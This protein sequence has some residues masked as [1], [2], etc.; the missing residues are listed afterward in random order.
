[1][2]QPVDRKLGLEIGHKLTAFKSSRRKVNKLP[3]KVLDAPAL[4]DDFYLNLIDWSPDNCLVVGLATSVYLWNASN[5]RVT[6]LCD[7]GIENIATSVACSVKEPL[8]SLGT[9]NG[10]VQI[11]DIEKV[12]LTRTLTGH[13][14][15][16]GS[17]SWSTT[18][19]ST[20]SRDKKIIQRDL[21]AQVAN[22][23]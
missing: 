5:A 18:L 2:E 1:M 10:D 3:V 21:R 22:V 16:V 11:W 9:Q 19:L 17:M 15:R 4:Q 20:G 7:L 8:I 6:K 13:S 14:L 23:Q 12:K